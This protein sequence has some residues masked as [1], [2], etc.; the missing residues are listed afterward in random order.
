[1]VILLIYTAVLDLIK[2]FKCQKDL[3]AASNKMAFNFSFISMERALPLAVKLI[4]LTV[5]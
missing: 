5:L 3:R 4:M 1:V 2:N